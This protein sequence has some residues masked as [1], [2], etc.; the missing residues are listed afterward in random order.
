MFWLLGL[1]F[2]LGLAP[3][4]YVIVMIA[5]NLIVSLPITPWN[6]GTYEF[7]VG[8]VAVG[9]GAN[10]S[11]AAAYAFGTHI[12]TIIWITITGLMALWLLDLS[13]RDILSL[14][15]KEEEGEEGEEGEEEEEDL[16]GPQRWS[17]LG[18]G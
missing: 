18:A 14:G 11:V 10:S 15:R 9:L 2:G 16:E 6:L 4:E 3:H 13:L 1:A 12:F 17:G 7:V 5:A 8:G